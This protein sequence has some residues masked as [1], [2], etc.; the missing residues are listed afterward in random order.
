MSARR[1]PNGA[2][3][4]AAAA[5]PAVPTDLD[6]SLVA[7][8]L[9]RHACN[10][11]DAAQDLGVSSS[12]LRRLMWANPSLQ[13]AAL[14]VV[15]GRV[16]LAERNIAESLRSDDGRERLAA[17]MFTIRNSGR[18]R[19]RGWITSAAPVDLNVD[20]N[21]PPRN[22][23][24]RWAGEDRETDVIERDA[25]KIPVPRYSVGRD[26]D[27]LEGEVAASPALIERAAA[28]ASEPDPVVRELPPAAPDPVVRHER[29]RIDAWIRNRLIAYPLASCF[30]CRKPIVVGQDWQ[31]VSNGEERAR[32]HRACHDEWRTEREA[33]ARQALGLEG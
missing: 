1:R 2:I 12:A 6:L 10:V 30:G 33:A 31:E 16:D 8:V 4:A 32:F 17:S 22:I 15:E 20:S 9:A 11:T 29:E 5:A 13:D 23:V 14:E 19:R 26:D 21:Q 3:A 18:A 27:V 7:A 24:I 28:V 25:V